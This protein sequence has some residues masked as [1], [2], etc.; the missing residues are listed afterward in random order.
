MIIPVRCVTCGKVLADKYEFYLSEVR[1]LKMESG[2]QTKELND[3]VVYFNPRNAEKTIEGRVLDTIGL[4]KPCCRR[5][6]LTHVDI[7]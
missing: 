3:N 1:R 6:M 4:K 7:E 2:D 5:H